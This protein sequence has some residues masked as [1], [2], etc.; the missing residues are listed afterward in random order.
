M[1]SSGRTTQRPG[2]RAARRRQAGDA[3][4][5]SRCATV[6]TCRSPTR[7]ASRGSAPRSP[8]PASSSHDLTW[9]SHVVAVVTDGIAVLGLGDIGPAASLPV[10]EGK[11]VLFKEFAG[12]DAVPDLPRRHRRSTTSSRPSCGSRRR[13]A[14]STSRT[15][16]RRGASRSSGSCGNGSTSRSSTTTSTARPSSCLPPCATP[17]G[18]PAA[19]LGDLRAVVSGAGAAGVAVTTILREAGIGDI[20]VTDREGVLHDGRG[21][22][23]TVKRHLAAATNDDRPHRQPGR[24]DARRR[25]LHRRL[26]RGRSRR[27]RSRRWP[28]TRSSSP[29]PTRDPEIAP[30][31]GPPA[32]PGR[33]DRAQRLPNQINNVLAFPGIFRGALD[34]RATDIT[35]GMKLAAAEAH[36]GGRR[37]RPGRRLR[38]AEP[39]RRAGGPGGGRGGGG[40]G[41]AGRWSAAALTLRLAVVTVRPGRDSEPGG[42]GGG[43]RPAAAGRGAACGAAARRGGPR[44]PA[45]P[46]RSAARRSVRV[47]STPGWFGG[48]SR[49]I[50]SVEIDDI[51]RSARKSRCIASFPG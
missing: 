1:T 18:S 16:A 27:R 4:R 32:R 26:G 17:R 42:H 12:V 31:R 36:R 40:R 6:T 50:A 22:L 2:L 37:R 38:R 41:R 5:P 47:M 34:V 7:R 28:R 30:R 39:V 46:R 51:S 25:R 8:R 21:D 9:K 44:G 23:T 43:L 19:A 49:C 29:W 11:A 20:T 24:G 33:G 45:V 14:A 15:S 35:E 48:C 13:S 10:M 3:S